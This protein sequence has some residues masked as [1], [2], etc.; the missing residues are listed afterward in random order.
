MSRPALILCNGDPPSPRLM[1]R[2]ARPAGTIVAADGGA[3]AAR[4]CGVRPDV[5]IGDLDSITP[6]TR[7]WFRSS[8]LIRV[9][10][11]DNTDLEKA[12]DF[13]RRERVREV[14]IAGAAGRRLDFTLGNLSVAFL[15][16]GGMKMVFAGDGWQAFPL[17]R[18]NRMQAPPGTTVSLIPFSPCN[19]V[20]LR[21]LA[22]SLTGAALTGGAVAVS[23]VVARSP[24]TVNVRSGR[25]LMVMFAEA[26]AGRVPAL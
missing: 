8:R 1:R 12:L 6:A 14:V 26:P 20:T 4:A 5:I 11:Q 10:R 17:A 2:L 23:N 13:L 22:Y 15:Y 7:R 24:F 18:R 16:A 21:G 25:L 3:N 9:R 19:G